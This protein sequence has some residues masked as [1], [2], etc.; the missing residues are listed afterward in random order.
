M[1]GEMGMFLSFTITNTLG[2]P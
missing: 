1:K 2:N